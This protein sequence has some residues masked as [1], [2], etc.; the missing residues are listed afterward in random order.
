[1]GSCFS[2]NRIVDINEARQLTLNCLKT[3]V[4]TINEH[5]GI[6]KYLWKFPY[7]KKN[8]ELRI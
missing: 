5:E 2:L 6:R 7:S 3:Y 8:I 4:D 1:M